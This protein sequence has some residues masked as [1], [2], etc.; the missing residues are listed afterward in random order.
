MTTSPREPN[1]ET[2]EDQE[3]AEAPDE[4]PDEVPERAAG[5]GEPVEPP[6]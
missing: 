1:D 5:E 3:P 6:D 4:E 2:R